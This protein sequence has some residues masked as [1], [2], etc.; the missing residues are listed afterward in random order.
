MPAK[1]DKL[2][3]LR[4]YLGNDDQQIKEMLELFLQNIPNDLNE[5]SLVCKKNDIDG[6]QKTAHRLKSSVRFFSLDDVATLLQQ[7][8]TSSKEQ[9]DFKQLNELTKQINKLMEQEL[10][11]FEK[12]LSRF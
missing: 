2:S 10:I 8:E 4:E 7:I 5:L 1:K 9:P 3:L 12:M 11:R 6:I